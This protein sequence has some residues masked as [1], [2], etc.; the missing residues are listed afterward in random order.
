MN[1][2]KKQLCQLIGERAYKNNSHFKTPSKIVDSYFDFLEISLKHQ[3]VK[4]AGDLLYEEVK[5]LDICALGGPG[6]GIVSVLCRASFLQ[7]IGVFYIRESR[8]TVGDLNAPLWLE[9]RIREGDRVA[10]AA[11]VVLSGS[12]VIRA[13]EE[14]M[15]FGGTLVKIVVF[16]DSQDGDGIDKIRSFLQTNMMDVPV[17]VLFTREE[18]VATLEAAPCPCS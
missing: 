8:K 16:I 13:I 14:I 10:L 2:I 9:S 3:G 15:Q 4:L 7:E 1:T 12:L 11:D 17:S 18:I 5:D 6:H